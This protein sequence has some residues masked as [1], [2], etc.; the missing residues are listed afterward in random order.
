MGEDGGKEN[1]KHTGRN[2][3]MEKETSKNDKW[4]SKID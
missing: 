2:N 1:E 3:N 4:H